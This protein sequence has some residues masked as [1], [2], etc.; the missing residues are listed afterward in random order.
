MAVILVVLPLVGCASIFQGADAEIAFESNVAG[1]TILVDGKPSGVTAP[2]GRE[3][4]VKVPRRTVPVV[5]QAEGYQPWSVQLDAGLD[6]PW[7]ILDIVFGVIP[8]FVDLANGAWNGVTPD[9]VRVDLIP[10]GR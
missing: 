9:R 10:R 6:V 5:V 3:V 4:K 7:L 2:P 1:A 8:L